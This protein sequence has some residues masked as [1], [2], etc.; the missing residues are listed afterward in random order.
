MLAAAAPDL[1]P[2]MSDE[3]AAAVLPGVKLKYNAREYDQLAAALRGKAQQLNGGAGMEVAGANEGSIGGS[4]L[5]IGYRCRGKLIARTSVQRH[6]TSAD[7][8]L[9]TIDAPMLTCGC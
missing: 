6:G 3:A 5:R 1:C 7:V 8:P 9:L 2:F 4:L